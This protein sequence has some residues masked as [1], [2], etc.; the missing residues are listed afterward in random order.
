[1]FTDDDVCSI[2]L[3]SSNNVVFCHTILTSNLF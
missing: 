1:M 3:E 2:C